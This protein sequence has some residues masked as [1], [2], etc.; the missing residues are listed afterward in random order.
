MTSRFDAEEVLRAAAS[1]AIPAEGETLIRGEDGWQFGSPAVSDLDID[2]G[3]ISGII[4]D[5]NQLP[6][7]IAYED[8][9]NTFALLQTFTSGVVIADGQSLSWSDIALSRGAAGR[10]DLASGDDFRIVSGQLQFGADVNLYR[11]SAN[12]LKTDDA[13]V[14][15]GNLDVTGTSAFT[16]VGIGTNDPARVMEIRV[17]SPILRLRATGDTETQTA[18][19]VEFGGTTAAAWSRTG[20][21]GD[22]SSGNTDIALRAEQSDLHL[23]DSS[24]PY[25]LNLQGGNVGIGETAPSYKLEVSGTFHVTGAATFSSVVTIDDPDEWLLLTDTA[26]SGSVDLTFQNA[27][28]G[29][30]AAGFQVGITASEKAILLNYENT[31]MLFYVNNALAATL[32]PGGGLTLAGGLTIADGQTLAW[33]DVNLYRVSVDVLK[34]DDDF[35]VDGDFSA[36]DGTFSGLISGIIEYQAGI[37]FLMMGA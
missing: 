14:V 22:D 32:A 12:V 19:Y 30:G 31:D 21:V 4:D 2:F 6:A 7:E 34:T 3:D 35:V 8:E 20:Y 27:T 1:G 37:H 36:V 24:G 5:R 23:G 13:F 25:V 33:S 17:V 16:T 28:T 26:T 11:V 9:V 18:A 15:E 29:T 10:L